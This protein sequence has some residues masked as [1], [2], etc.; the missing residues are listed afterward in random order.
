[1]DFSSVSAF[2]QIV[3]ADIILSG[4]NALVIGLAAASLP[5]EQRRKAIVFGMVTAA[6]LRVVFAI[7]A[8]VLLKIDGLLFLGG[9]LLFWVCW[10]LYKEIR[11][12]IAK[13]AKEATGDNDLESATSPKKSFSQALVSIVIADVSMSLDNVLAV[14]AIAR[15]SMTLLVFGLVLAIA[16]MGFCASLIVKILN[17]YPLISWFGLFVLIYVA[18]DMVSSG[19]PSMAMILGLAS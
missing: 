9:L 12:H 2:F 14:A 16:L 18:Y 6:V 5:A 13:T 19:W 15:D 4:D 11:A 17:R 10:R 1:M 7:F 8:T 3:V